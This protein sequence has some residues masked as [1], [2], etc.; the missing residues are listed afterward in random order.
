MFV[1]N[2]YQK[3][4]FQSECSHFKILT[5]DKSFVTRF[6]IVIYEKRNDNRAEVL[7][8]IL[9]FKSFDKLIFVRIEKK[10]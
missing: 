10:V 5:F 9:Y 1:N 3:F 8:C 6:I 7:Q 4:L 2:Y